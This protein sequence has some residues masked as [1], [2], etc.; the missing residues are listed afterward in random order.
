MVTLFGGLAAY[1]TFVIT[2]VAF[3]G[4]GG[5]VRWLGCLL[6][7]PFARRNP[8]LATKFCQTPR[9]WHKTG[10]FA[11]SK[12]NPGPVPHLRKTDLFWM[13]S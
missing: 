6:V 1:L 10:R 12:P 8:W 4:L 9:F 3:R 13:T 2:T 11:E 5:G 7:S